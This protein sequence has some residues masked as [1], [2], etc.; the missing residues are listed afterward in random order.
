MS[1]NVF[2]VDQSSKTGMAAVLDVPDFCSDVLL[3][4]SGTN[5][6]L[7][8]RNITWSYRNQLH[9]IQ[10]GKLWIQDFHKEA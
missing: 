9:S 8:N 4:L 7:K 2:E 6:S 1:E 10:G 3:T 5:G